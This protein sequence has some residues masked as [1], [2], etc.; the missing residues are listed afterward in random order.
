MIVTVNADGR[1]DEANTILRRHGAYDMHTSGPA[2]ATTTTA[3]AASAT[4]TAT[5]TRAAMTAGTAATHHT[6]GQQR[7]QVKEEELHAHKHPVE[8]GEV[9]VRKE[10]HTE[11]KTVEV[12]VR[13]AE[14][15]IERHAPT[16]R[17]AGAWDIGPG[18]EIRVPVME[19][20]VT[21]EK[22]P[23]VKEEVS[24]GKR[25]VHETERVAGE[26]RKEEVHVERK[27]DVDVRGSGKGTTKP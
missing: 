19:E 21:V 16:G 12:P 26:V 4:G 17:G 1:A 3:G 13:K 5:T 7:I 27:G 6:E 23:V 9:R 20:R 22:T 10:V 18:E 15:V 2:T 14:V 24:V 11:H 8:A 25:V